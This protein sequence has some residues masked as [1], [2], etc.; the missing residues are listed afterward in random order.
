MISF[1][2]KK[3]KLFIWLG[4]FFI[5]IGL[6]IF[7]LIIAPDVESELD[8]RLLMLFP[9]WIGVILIAIGCGYWAMAKG[10]SKTRGVIIGL[11]TNILAPIILG[12]HSDRSIFLSN[13]DE[14]IP[15]GS[16]RKNG[17]RCANCGK[18]VTPFP[19]PGGMWSGTVGELASMPQI[20]SHHAFVCEDCHST[21]CPVCLGKK[22]SELGVRMFVCTQCGHKPVK[23]IYR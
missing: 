15:K 14:K 20:E 11:L 16:K 7:Y 3:I 10:Y 21:I 2:K 13:Y 4:Y 23:T 19:G 1:Y 8:N 5:V 22:A 9:M 18:N 12:Y 17:E 6:I